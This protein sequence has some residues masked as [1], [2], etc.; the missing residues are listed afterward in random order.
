MRSLLHALWRNLGNARIATKLLVSFGLLLTLTAIIGTLSYVALARLNQAAST[1]ADVWLPGVGELAAARADMLIVREFEVKH[2]HASDD[3]YRSEY[4]EKMNAALEGVKRHFEA[5]KSDGGPLA[6]GKLI[7]ESEGHWTEYLTVNKKIINLSRSG[8]QD[9]AQEVGDGAG[10]SAIDEALTALERLTDFSFAQ[11]R[12]AGVHSRDVYRKAVTISSVA[13]TLILILGSLLTWVIIRSITHPIGEAVR[14][15]QSIASGDLTSPVEVSSTN[16]TGQLLQALKSMQGVLRENE[17]EALNAK[18]QITAI[19]KTQAVTEFALD[20]T[21]RVANEHLLRMFGYSFAEIKGRHHGIFVEP[22][23]R[24]RPEY[25]AF[26][27]KLGRGEYEA[28]QYKRMAQGGREIFLRASYNA[29]LGLDGKPYKIVEYAS[30]VTDQVRMQADQAAMQAEQLKMKE[31][32]D[33]AVAETQEVVQSAID[34]ALTKRISITGKSGQIEALASSINSLIDSMMTMVTAIKRAANEVQLGARDISSGNFNLSHRTEQQAASLEETAASME[35]MTTTVQA[36]AENA[37]QAERLAVAARA[38]AE[39]G[40]AVVSSA[41]EAMTGINAAS[42]RISDIIGVIDE[43]A[44]QTNLLALNA[45]VEAARAGEQGRGF[46]VVAAEV[47]NLA[48]RSA[49]AA[50]EIKGLIQETVGKVEDGSKLVDASGTVLRE[51]VAGVKKVTDVVAEIAASSQEQASG[52]EQVNKA[53]MSMDEMTQQ[54]AALVEEASAAAQSL[55][56]QA[57]NLSQLMARYQ[58]GDASSSASRSSAAN[59]MQRGDAN[60]PWAGNPKRV[61]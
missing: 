22:A 47:R 29:V 45:A 37:A 39:K 40:G 36:T 56:E 46:A 8:K 60:R 17:V 41:I 20:G 49:A 58:V 55:T 52:I 54:N 13:A 3:G 15:A 30:D 27:A 51:I 26:W 21:I 16:E 44:F 38:Q 31:A 12:A 32:L 4:E 33:L 18:G 9:D 11:G 53:V 61:A 57:A 50:K 5:F 10:K 23:V 24:S 7:V 25:L 48:S 6:D 2:T 28:G 19:N 14:V 1:L 42:K 35:E 59:S 34:G 43:I